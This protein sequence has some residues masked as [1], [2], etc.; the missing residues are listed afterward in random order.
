MHVKDSTFRASFRRKPTARARHDSEERDAVRDV[1]GVPTSI[2]RTSGGRSLIRSR[3]GPQ[4]QADRDSQRASAR[5]QRGRRRFTCTGS[6]GPSLTDG[7][8]IDGIAVDDATT[9]IAIRTDRANPGR[10]WV[11]VRS[12]ETRCARHHDAD[13]S[14]TFLCQLGRRARIVL[15]TPIDL[16][17]H[18]RRRGDFKFVTDFI[19]R[20][21][22]IL[23]SDRG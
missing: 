5:P 16:T 17:I 12:K 7:K 9:F 14:G 4:R 3:E 2:I 10:G 6:G 23:K 1:E 15:V 13:G 18:V 8:R 20:G 22:V 21:G 11:T 19:G